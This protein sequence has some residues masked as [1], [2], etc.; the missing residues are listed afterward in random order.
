VLCEHKREGDRWT[1]K[2]LPGEP[3][4]LADV[5]ARRKPDQFFGLILPDNMAAVVLRTTFIQDNDEGLPA[6]ADETE[7]AA[8]AAGAWSEYRPD[9]VAD[10]AL[11]GYTSSPVKTRGGRHVAVIGSGDLVPLNGKEDICFERHEPRQQTL[12]SIE[13]A[14]ALAEANLNTQ[15]YPPTAGLESMVDGR[16]DHSTAWPDPLIE[17]ILPGGG[18]LAV[19]APTTTGKTFGLVD[20]SMHVVH[21]LPSWLGH[22]IGARRHSGS[23]LYC[24]SEGDASFRNRREGWLGAHPEARVAGAADFLA[25]YGGL[26]LLDDNGAQLT[27]TLDLLK[28]Q[29]RPPALI[30]IDTL[31]GHFGRGHQNDDGDMRHF[32]DI[33]RGANQKFGCAAAVLH[34]PGLRDSRRGRGSGVLREAAD[35]ELCL[36]CRISRLGTG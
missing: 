12:G 9:G 26:A 27:A 3:A 28:K 16:F 24:L 4:P 22:K 33:V 8:R 36:K 23:V 11:V 31:S 1:I 17:G 7:S 29:W 32:V 19:V 2:R 35:V 6:W 14:I 20:L 15:V 21:G 10:Y 13:P 25:R 5:M 34:H 18:I 30:V